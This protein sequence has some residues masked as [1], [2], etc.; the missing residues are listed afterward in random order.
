MCAFEW[1]CL[2]SGLALKYFLLGLNLSAVLDAR[3]GGGS[4]LEPL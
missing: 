4:Y 2:L 1:V 3:V